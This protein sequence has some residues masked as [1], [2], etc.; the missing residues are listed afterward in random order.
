[1]CSK[2]SFLCFL[3]GLG[4]GV[5]IALLLAPMSGR[6]ARLTLANQARDTA[7]QAKQQAARVRDSAAD[8]LHKGQQ[9]VQR[10][11]ESLKHGLEA[12]VAA[13]QA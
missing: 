9:Q 1:M 4:G 10:Q 3:V 2:N 5:G 11:K 7:D 6:Q 13:Y 8:I 12:G